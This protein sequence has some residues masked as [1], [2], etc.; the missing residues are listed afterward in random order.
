MVMKKSLLIVIS[1]V[2]VLMISAFVT[3][4]LY[5]SSRTLH[6]LH[7]LNEHLDAGGVRLGM[8][9]REVQQLLGKGTFIVG[10]GGY[11]R[12]YPELGLLL[13]FPTDQE[14]DLH[15][16]VSHMEMTN[17][18]YSV[19]GIRVGDDPHEA[20]ALLRQKRFRPVDDSPDTVRLGE[21]SIKLS[22]QDSIAAIHIRFD[23]KDLRDILY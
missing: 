6:T 23:D 3:F 7:Y 11:A 20:L 1:M 9:D 4:Y 22:G 17:P 15:D 18:E 8:P 10:F 2:A 16:S 21:F 12:E 19:F 14:N 5:S 13:S